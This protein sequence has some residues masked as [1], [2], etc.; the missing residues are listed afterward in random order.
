MMSGKL[1]DSLPSEKQASGIKAQIY[2]VIDRI[3][4]GL[5]YAECDSLSGDSKLRV[6]INNLEV[7]GYVGGADMEKFSRFSSYEKIRELRRKASQS[8]TKIAKRN[9]IIPDKYDK[10]WDFPVF[11]SSSESVGTVF[12]L[13]R[14]T[15]VGATIVSERIG[16]N[17]EILTIESKD[18]KHVHEL[19]ILLGG[20]ASFLS[21]IES[22]S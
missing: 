16:Q 17:G 1:I 11:I 13:F 7:I 2:S 10:E 4:D 6:N 12:M 15:S 22:D 18:I 20:L 3:D 14:D 5:S 9:A 8:M 21:A 19:K